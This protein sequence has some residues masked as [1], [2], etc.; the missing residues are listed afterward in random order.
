V[1]ASVFSRALNVSLNGNAATMSFIG[2]AATLNGSADN[3]TLGS[4]A[5]TVAAPIQTGVEVVRGFQ[6]GSDILDIALGN[7]DP[8][9]LSLSNVTLGGQSSVAIKLSTDP[10]HGVILVNPGVSASAVLDNYLFT[11]GTHVIIS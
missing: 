7:G 4:A 2:A 10:T 11:A 3:L 1:D 6:F 8:A 9:N 5:A